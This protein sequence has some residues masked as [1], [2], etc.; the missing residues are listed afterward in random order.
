MSE[1]IFEGNEMIISSPYS[2]EYV[3]E[4]KA[5]VI[6]SERRFARHHNGYS[7]VWIVHPKHFKEVKSLVK[8]IY[9]YCD[10]EGA[11]PSAGESGPRE[12]T[13]TLDYLGTMKERAEGNSCYGFVNGN[14]NGLFPQRAIEEW[15][16][17]G[18]LSSPSNAGSL[19]AVLGVGRNADE[20]AI[21]KAYRRGA[22]TWHP[23]V[24]QEP[25][26]AEQFKRIKA[27][28]D[29]LSDRI[30]RAKYMA[31][32]QFESSSEFG[33]QAAVLWKPAVKC[34]RIRAV[35]QPGLG[36][37][38]VVEKIVAWDDQVNEQ[39]LTRVTHWD[40]DVMDWVEHGERDMSRALTKRY[41]D[42][43]GGSVKDVARA[44][45]I[46]LAEAFMG[47]DHIAILDVSGSMEICD[48]GQGH[49]QRHDVAER[50]LRS[51]QEKYPGQIALIVY[52][53]EVKYCPNGVPDRLNGGTSTAA[54]LRYVQIADGA[55][56][57][58]LIS[59]GHPSDS[60]EESYRVASTFK[61]HINTIY[62]G[63]EHDFE[64][65]AFMRKI[66]ELSGGK[67]VTAK[68]IAELESPF[69]QILLLSGENK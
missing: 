26:A 50:E 42:L 32:L 55:L 62:I 61:S 17:L 9:G 19:F 8:R 45:N 36:D 65:Q 12:V 29:I 48:A 58:F 34:G 41:K 59:D 37:K 38:F 25:D 15:F 7:N 44:R 24:C 64:A 54:A 35:I 46:S 22:R 18:D 21:K 23:D 30:L 57:F 3:S 43:A 40:M 6:P 68:R 28:Y 60:A 49:E 69:E 16:G 14:W 10:V 31:A 13:F 53:S 39:G 11:P 2:Q 56:D 5:M 66:A 27:A 47:V 33:S 63:P 51:L 1:I 4:L 52:S 67:S 20:A